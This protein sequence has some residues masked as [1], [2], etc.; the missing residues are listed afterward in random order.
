MDD[1]LNTEEHHAHREKFKDFPSREII[2][3]YDQREKEGITPKSAWEK[4]GEQGYFRPWVGKE[5]AGTGLGLAFSYS[6][7][8]QMAYVIPQ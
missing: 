6:I 5:F 2:P 7:T 4:I 1:P 8:E 3:F